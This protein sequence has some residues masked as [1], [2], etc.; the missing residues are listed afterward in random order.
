[1]R[2]HC[3]TQVSA[4]DAL[5]QANIVQFYEWYETKHHLHMIMEFVPYGDLGICVKESHFLGVSKIKMIA[6]QICEALDFIHSHG[7]VHRDIKPENILVASEEPLIVKLSDFGLS[8]MI[9][10][11]NK[12]FL[13]TF[14]GTLLY[15]APEVYPGFQQRKDGRPLSRRAKEQ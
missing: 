6:H 10:H 3:L 7:I 8:K 9:G 5:G 13:K 11:D 4:N 14:C 12:T 15:C 2:E 1:M